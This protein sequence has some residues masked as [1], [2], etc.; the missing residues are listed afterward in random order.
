VAGLRT[1]IVRSPVTIFPLMR[2]LKPL[3]GLLSL[4]NGT[5][6]LLR[7]LVVFIYISRFQPEEHTGFA[8]HRVE[9]GLDGIV[10]IDIFYEI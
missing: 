10:G 3:I 9:T 8:H 6:F 1:G 2:R 4:W 5:I 7:G